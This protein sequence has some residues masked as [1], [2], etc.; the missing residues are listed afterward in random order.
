MTRIVLIVL[1]ITVTFGTVFIF[2]Q[3]SF[4]KDLQVDD[5]PNV[6]IISM[7][8]VPSYK[9]SCY[10]Y[11]R[12]IS[13]SICEVADNGTIY[14]RAYSSTTWAV[15]SKAGM[16]TGEYP[17]S[18]RDSE[19]DLMSEDQELLPEKLGELGYSTFQKGVNEEAFEVDYENSF[20]SSFSVSEVSDLLE[21]DSPAYI[22]YSVWDTHKHNMKEDIS[23]RDLYYANSINNSQIELYAGSLGEDLEDR[24]ENH[25]QINKTYLNSIYD[26]NLLYTDKNHIEP[27]I[28]QLKEAEAYED[29]LIIITSTHGQLL[30]Q[31]NLYGHELAYGHPDELAQVPLIVKYPEEKDAKRE[32]NVV[33]TIDITPAVLRAVGY[34][35]SD[36]DFD[37]VPLQDTEDSRSV[38]IERVYEETTSV[39]N[40]S[41]KLTHCN[42]VKPPLCSEEWNLYSYP[43]EKSVENSSVERSMKE[44][45]TEFI[46]KGKTRK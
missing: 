14:E 25:N 17:A 4:E 26:D 40:E 10:G 22:H 30:G 11:D 32:D 15:P 31:E 42:L 7:A 44:K 20:D 8:S 18:L 23:N 38:F 41:Y 2:D 16:M 3:P 37:G 5:R 1:I 39:V 19:N 33:S 6:V 34:G 12:E 21:Q 36:E 43:S 46:E 27:I 28:S 35:K 9:I 45:L 29:S 24:R 13:P